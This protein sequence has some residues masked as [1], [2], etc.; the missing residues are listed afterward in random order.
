MNVHGFD[1]VNRRPRNNANSNANMLA[2][3]GNFQGLNI[4]H[5]RT[6]ETHKVLFLSG[7]RKV[8]NPKDENYLDMLK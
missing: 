1:E 6:V 2:G 4:E 7:R 5:L 3:D 8:K